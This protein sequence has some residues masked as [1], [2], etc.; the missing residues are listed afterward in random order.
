MKA[1]DLQAGRNVLFRRTV[2][3]S[4]QAE[5]RQAGHAHARQMR[6]GIGDPSPPGARSPA[7]TQDAGSGVEVVLPAASS[8]SDCRQEFPRK[9]AELPGCFV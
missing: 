2:M 9:G 6:T 5:S 7:S 3:P 4:I 1:L 8:F